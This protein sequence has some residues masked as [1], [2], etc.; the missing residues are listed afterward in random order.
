MHHIVRFWVPATQARPVRCGCPQSVG[1]NGF[2]KN[3]PDFQRADTSQQKP[4]L[5]GRNDQ[6]DRIL[7]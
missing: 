2:L 4:M 6:S 1:A 7:S 3:M 5:H